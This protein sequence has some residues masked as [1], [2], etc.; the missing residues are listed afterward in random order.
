MLSK[1]YNILPQFLQDLVIDIHKD[2][3]L[4]LFFFT[5]SIKNKRCTG[6]NKKILTDFNKSRKYGP[7]NK[8]CYAPYTSMFFSRSGLVSPC[9]AS[10]NDKSSHIKSNSIKDIWFNGSF[11]AIREQHK[12]CD[13]SKNC[14]FCKEIMDKTAYESLLINKYEHYAFSKSKYPAIMEFEISNKCNLSCIMCDSNLSSS[15]EAGNLEKISGNQYYDDKF[16]EQLIEFI[17]HLQLAE[18]TGGD[19]FMIQEYYKIWEM[20]AEINP[21]CNILITTNANTMNSRIE[22]LLETHRNIHFNVSI[23][24]L[25]KENYE[26]IR[27]G[28]N[29]DFALRNLDMFIK[30]T[31]KHNTSLNMLVCPMTVNKH[32]LHS[33]VDFANEKNI[34]VFYHT[35]VKPKGLSL[36][37]LD[38]NILMNTIKD[39]EKFT[40]DTKTKNQRTNLKNYQNL[41]SLLKSWHDE[42]TDEKCDKE[43]KLL[44]EAE[45]L[46]LIR[47]KILGNEG[48]TDKMTSLLN[49]L[50]N[51]DSYL[52]II[53]RLANI[54][55]DVFI[56]YLQSK[57]ID[58]L[59]QICINIGNKN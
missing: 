38:K 36:K 23:D 58:E 26:K 45:A 59:K 13:L 8:I 1:V 19:P 7:L 50:N 16:I 29:L 9:Y 21:K 6:I 56:E 24:S 3:R 18:F 52:L 49:R 5:S 30:Y 2:L 48:L 22:K 20:I 14:K 25:E 33:F 27:R 55:D 11:K 35:V 34:C 47:S 40:S 17:P 54:K 44:S 12:T 39:M 15:L 31:K 51:S 32:E 42:V 53:N 10:Y 4:L 57:T 41:I 37:Y 28:G 46:E 43:K